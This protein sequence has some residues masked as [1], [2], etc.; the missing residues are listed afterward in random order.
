MDKSLWEQITDKFSSGSSS[1]RK[2]ISTVM[3]DFD[4][5]SLPAFFTFMTVVTAGLAVNY[6]FL[7]SSG[8]DW[9]EALAISMLFEVG[10]LAWKFQGHRVKNSK[11]QAGIS[12]IATW[13]STVFAGLM[14]FSSLSGKQNYWGWIVGGAAITHVVSFLI[15]DAND[16]IRNNKRK[17]RSANERVK[18]KEIETDNALSEAEADLKII[19]RITQELTSLRRN[20]MDLPTEELEFVLDATRTRLLAEYK[21]SANVQEATKGLADVNGDGLI[22]P[23]RR[24]Q[25]QNF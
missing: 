24:H 6:F 13:L 10:I 19:R 22:G 16:T 25:E 2:M 15:F 7:L 8:L 21:A 18:Q 14:L 5:A 4:L 23:A 9:R 1:I 3:D 17:N 11:A 12:T 20:N